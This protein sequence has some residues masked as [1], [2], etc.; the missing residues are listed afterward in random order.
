MR[1]LK[2]HLDDL[3]VSTFHTLPERGANAHGTLIAHQEAAVPPTTDGFISPTQGDCTNRCL[4]HG[5]PTPYCDTIV[6]LTDT[7]V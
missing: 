1:K 2:L 5:P 6:C 4:T 3:A 7:C